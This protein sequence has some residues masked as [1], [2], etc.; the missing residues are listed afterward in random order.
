[1]LILSILPQLTISS[2]LYRRDKLTA[3]G[4]FITRLQLA[5]TVD[6]I[7]GAVDA[8]RAKRLRGFKVA[9]Q[10]AKEKWARKKKKKKKTDV[11]QITGRN[12]A[13]LTDQP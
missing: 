10:V 9:P 3:Q 6:A 11:R 5:D 2:S 7:Y 4:E 8:K 13:S 12:G 1:V